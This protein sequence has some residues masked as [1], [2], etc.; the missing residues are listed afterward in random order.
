MDDER[1]DRIYNYAMGLAEA[2][3]K[4]SEALEELVTLAGGRPEPL[5]AALERMTKTV[6][7][8]AGEPSPGTED[9]GPPEGTAL[10]ASRLLAEAVESLSEE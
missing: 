8:R 6:D 5:R 7:E 4:Q 2:R 3:V 9:T 10:L 1:V